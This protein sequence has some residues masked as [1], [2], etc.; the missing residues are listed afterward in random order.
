[1]G[2]QRISPL[3]GTTLPR[4]FASLRMTCRPSCW[5]AHA[6]ALRSLPAELGNFLLC[7]LGFEPGGSLAVAA[8][9]DRRNHWRCVTAGKDPLASSPYPK[10]FRV[11]PSRKLPLK[12]CGDSLAPLPS[13]W[14]SKIILA[15]SSDCK[16]NFPPLGRVSL[17]RKRSDSPD[18][19]AGKIHTIQAVVK[20]QELATL[21]R[22]VRANQEIGKNPAWV[23]VSLLP[24]AGRVGLQRQPCRA[25]DRL[26]QVPLHAD[27]G[28]FT[29]RHG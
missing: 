6:Q 20:A 12:R 9:S 11:S 22:R 13:S 28:V 21:L 1:V 19:K 18:H 26:I 4:S 17:G 14:Q 25:P 23:V 10:A 2:R 5:H 24:P 3:H 27:P 16:R 29:D 7:A 8:T 15:S